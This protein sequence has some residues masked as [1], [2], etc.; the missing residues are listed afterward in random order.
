V[1]YLTQFSSSVPLIKFNIDQVLMTI[2]QDLAM[3]ICVPEDG[4]AASHAIIEAINK[5]G[6]YSF[7]VKSSKD[8]L[9]VEQNGNTVSQADLKDGDWLNIGG[10][11]FQFTDDGVNEIKEQVVSNMVTVTELKSDSVQAEK[12]IPKSKPVTELEVEEKTMSTKEFVAN[13]RYSRRRMSF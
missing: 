7:F 5:S 9:I 13:S 11:E 12:K 3:D 2:G 1:A 4:V 8:D 10:I 6:S